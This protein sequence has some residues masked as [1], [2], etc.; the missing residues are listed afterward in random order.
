[1]AITGAPEL[2]IVMGGNATAE[3]VEDVVTR[4]E[5]AGCGAVVTPGREATVIGAIGD[6]ELLAALPLEGYEGVEQVL[7]ILKPYKLVSR[8]LSPDSTV[9]SVRGRRIGDGYFGL[10]AG[11]CTVEYREQTMETARVVAAAGST[12]LRGGA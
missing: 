11:P 1:M 9:I 3:Q 6:R 2:L 12:M 8:E 4:L 10:I 7:P 5:E